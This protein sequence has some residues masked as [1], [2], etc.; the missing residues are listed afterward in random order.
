MTLLVK[1][2]M[3]VLIVE[4][5]LVGGAV[6]LGTRMND[7]TYS[8]YHV[9]VADEMG[10]GWDFYIHDESRNLLADLTHRPCFEDLMPEALTGS[11]GGCLYVARQHDELA[12]VD[13]SSGMRCRL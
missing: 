7:G 11:Q 10:Y 4:C 9:P 8:V 1:I 2:A 6:S 5:I 3:V 12:V 13:R